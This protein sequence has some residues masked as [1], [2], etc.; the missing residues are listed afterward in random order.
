[1]ARRLHFDMQDTSTRDIAV[2]AN[3]KV[4]SHV[5]D[6]IRFREQLSKQADLTNT[7]IAD[8]GEKITGLQIKLATALGILLFAGKVVDYVLIWKGQK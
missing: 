8:L 4:D 2:G 6:C 1:M 3:A 7:A 5:A